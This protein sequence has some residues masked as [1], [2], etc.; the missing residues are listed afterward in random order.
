MT[1]ISLGSL[2]WHHHCLLRRQGLA[3]VGGHGHQQSF[4]A[5]DQIAGVERGQLEAVAVCNGVSGAGLNAIAAE[6]AAVVVDVIDLGVALGAAD[7]LFFGIVG[8][9]NV[10]AVG[11]ARGR[12]QETGHAFFQTV[13]IALQLVQSAETLLKN[14][15]LIGQF[16]IG[17]VF[18]NRLGKHLLQGHGHSFG[19]AGEVTKDRHG[20]KYNAETTKDTKGRGVS[21]LTT[22][23]TKEHEGSW[24]GNV[25]RS[26]KTIILTDPRTPDAPAP[27]VLKSRGD[28]PF[29]AAQNLLPPLQCLWPTFL[30]E[31]GRAP[32]ATLQCAPRSTN[33]FPGAEA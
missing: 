16:F 18:H 21:A 2:L 33:L 28:R 11:R 14:R 5:I 4:F 19:D 15:A 27:A 26:P 7:A 13:L 30:R 9:F 23:D 20:D 3:G 12:T 10:N 17:I 32:A 6:N 22:K 29:P 25:E 31:P 24:A 1:A 8:R